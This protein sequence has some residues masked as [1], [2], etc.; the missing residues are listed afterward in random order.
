MP[1][2]YTS[3]LSWCYPPSLHPS[4]ITINLIWPPIRL[5]P[6]DLRYTSVPR[7][8][9]ISVT[10]LYTS[11]SIP[12]LFS[13]RFHRISL[14]FR[15]S[16]LEETVSCSVQVVIQPLLVSSL[17]FAHSSR[18][19]LFLDSSP[20]SSLVNCLISVLHLETYIYV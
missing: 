19:L 15:Y 1:V 17:I 7:S 18:F 16:V 11:H 10:N 5:S 6:V 12:T 13:L 3:R 20:D 8:N 2:V 14:R 4:I 9:A